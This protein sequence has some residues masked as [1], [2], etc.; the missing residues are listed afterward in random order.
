MNIAFFGHGC[1]V[2][3]VS[4]A[5]LHLTS[6][7]APL[8]A[9]PLT[10]EQVSWVGSMAPMG[11]LLGSIASGYVT[12]FIGCKRSMLML[13]I[14]SFL[15][16]LFVAFGDSYYYLLLARFSSGFAGGGFFTNVVLFVAEISN[17]K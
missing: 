7:D 17:D 9:G 15:F 4:P 12:S 2:G 11:A 5:I 1:I 8:P 14:P 10:L 13:S 16:W 3:W 6:D